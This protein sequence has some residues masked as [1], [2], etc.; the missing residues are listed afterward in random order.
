MIRMAAVG[1]ALPDDFHFEALGV[2]DAVL[3]VSK[4]IVRYS[5]DIMRT[6]SSA[7]SLGNG[8]LCDASWRGGLRLRV[9]L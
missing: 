2:L 4:M 5:P 9:R 1:N 7:R 6:S 3:V 8:V